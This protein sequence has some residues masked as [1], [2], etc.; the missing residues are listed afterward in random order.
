MNESRAEV[1][2]QCGKQDLSM[3]KGW[4]GIGTEIGRSVSYPNVAEKV[5]STKYVLTKTLDIPCCRSCAER[6]HTRHR[7]ISQTARWLCLACGVISLAT[8]IIYGLWFRDVRMSDG[9][10]GVFAAGLFGCGILA[11]AFACIWFFFSGD[12][13]QKCDEL[14]VREVKRRGVKADIYWTKSE[15]K[16]QSKAKG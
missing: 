4:C 6:R 8:A 10:A 13:K 9:W 11:I 3:L 16:T 14:A 12:L 7:Y 1:C 2:A 15:F 5:I